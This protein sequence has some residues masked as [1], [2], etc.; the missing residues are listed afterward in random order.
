MCFCCL[1]LVLIGANRNCMKLW[2]KLL[3]NERKRC[4]YGFGQLR[5]L[6]KWRPAE[7]DHE[8]CPA[9][10]WYSRIELKGV[11]VS[12]LDWIKQQGSA[13]WIG[14]CAYLTSYKDWYWTFHFRTLQLHKS[15]H[16]WIIRKVKNILHFLLFVLKN[17]FCYLIFYFCIDQFIPPKNI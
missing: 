1:K 12:I 5:K 9:L 14:Y 4:V 11:R 16:N 7:T 2:L 17:N 6:L 13:G 10:K 3:S 15:R 8:R